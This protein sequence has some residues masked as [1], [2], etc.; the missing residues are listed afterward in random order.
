M[1]AAVKIGLDKKKKYNLVIPLF[2]YLLIMGVVFLSCR[3]QYDVSKAEFITTPPRINPDYTNLTIPYNIAPMNFIIQEKGIKFLVNI[4]A[5]SNSII[6]VQSRSPRIKI[7]A[8]KWQ[9]LLSLNQGKA[10]NFDVFVFDGRWAKYKRF[11]NNVVEELIDRYLVYRFLQPN[12]TVQ[13]EMQIRQRDLQNHDESLVMTT[14][15][16]AGCINCHSFNQNDPSEMLFHIRWGV[17]AGTLFAQDGQLSKIDTRTKFNPS[18]GAYPSWHLSG[19][20]VAFSVNK[21]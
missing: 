6:S 15:P 18:P 11:S 5:D 21:V 12:Y 14:K 16:I 4:F 13:N 9:K 10:I 7:P 8:G 17:A 3:P 2:L 1:S 20:L 19:I